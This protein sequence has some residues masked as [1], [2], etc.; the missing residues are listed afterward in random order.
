MTRKVHGVASKL[1]R[2]VQEHRVQKWEYMIKPVSYS[3]DHLNKLGQEGWEICGVTYSDKHDL[4]VFY[5]K[6]LI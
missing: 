2:R 3:V 1:M 4:E 6:R 5:F